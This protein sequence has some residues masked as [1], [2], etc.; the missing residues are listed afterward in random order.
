MT[1]H[2]SGAEVCPHNGRPAITTTSCRTWMAP[3]A[4]RLLTV[5]FRNAPG[6]TVFT[7][8]Q[9]AAQSRGQSQRQSPSRAQLRGRLGQG[10]L[11]TRFP[12]FAPR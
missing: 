6:V 3:A 5:A 7:C 8:P 9:G 4:L 2:Q 1:S 10:R 12:C 11:L